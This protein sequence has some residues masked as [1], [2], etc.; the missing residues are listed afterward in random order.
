M[1]PQRGRRSRMSPVDT[2]WLRMDSPGN[3]MMIV[4]VMKLGPGFDEARMRQLIVER[5]LAYPRFRSRV[6]T[7]ASGAW[8]EEVEVDLD[9]HFVPVALPGRGGKT[10]LQALVGRLASQPLD[11]AR[12]LWQM[13]LVRDYEGG[14]AL[15]VRIHHCIADGIA[16]VGVLLSLTATSAAGNGP[17]SPAADAGEGAAAGERWDAWL[18]PLT[19]AAV[20]AIEVAGDLMQR[21]LRAYGRAL[22]EPER[23]GR[24]AAQSVAA[25][26]QLARDAAAL[27]L[28][29]NDSATSLKGKPGG[30][31]RVAWC[32]PL[33]LA[34]V[35]AVGKAL[36]CSVNDVLLACV[37]GALRGYFA[38]RGEPV[39]GV[40]VRAMVPVNLRGEDGAQTLGNRFGLLP[41]L[42]PIGIENPILRTL[43]VRRRMEALKGGYT[44][45][46]AMGILAFVGI[47]PRALQR[48]VLDLFGRKTTA[49]MT[50]VPG[51]RELLYLAGAPLEQLM[52]WVPQ[53]G[54]VAVGVSILSYNGAVQ[55]GLVTDARV[56]EAPQRISER[57]APEFEKLVY[58]LLLAPWDESLDSGVANAA[59][60]S[61][62][63]A[64]AIAGR[65]RNGAST[66]AAGAGTARRGRAARRA[67]RA[68]PP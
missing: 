38:E 20:R 31:K 42:L 39:D 10:D 28:M 17:G 48:Q 68:A 55:F 57:F 63:I 30:T 26:T 35:K 13:H 50:N 33:P 59:L 23:A 11:P 45:L 66:V 5:L 44:A 14:A 8:W 51:P 19:S 61:T 32:E 27:A 49:V 15:V 4:G 1:H 2:A 58:A 21:A 36:G 9:R 47:V 46:L 52:F 16:L 25:A 22:Q 29:E 7:D 56:C 24:A 53:S 60:A 65:M 54:D 37:A 62:E 6:V 3:L 43:Q 41:V 40:E 64:A 12:P 34:D 67:S 18:Q